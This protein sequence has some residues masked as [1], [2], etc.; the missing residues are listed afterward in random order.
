MPLTLVGGLRAARANL[1][2]IWVGAGLAH[3]LPWMTPLAGTRALQHQARIVDLSRDM[4][5]PF[6]KVPNRLRL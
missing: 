1:E 5:I 2:P 3:G 4:A 6:T